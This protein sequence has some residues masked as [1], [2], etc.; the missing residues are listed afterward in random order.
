MGQFHLD[1]GRM[2]PFG[3]FIQF[4]SARPAPNQHNLGHLQD[5]LLCHQTDPLAF[6]EG[7]ARVE[8]HADRQRAFVERG[9]EGARQLGGKTACRDHGRKN[10]CDQQAWVPERPLEQ[11]AI[12]AFQDPNDHAF[13]LIQPLQPRQ[14]V[15]GHDRGQRDRH[16]KAG[17]NRDD[18]GLPKWCKKP[19]LNAR[20]RKERYEDQNNGH[21]GVNDARPNL[22]AGRHDHVEDR[23]GISLLAVLA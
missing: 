9:Q 8:E 11:F 5:Q 21:R 1:L 23:A 18:I 2:H 19:P 13:M 16:D 12:A 10:P 20:Q 15:I 17:K 6:L 22:L 7:Y 3:V 14:H 4:R